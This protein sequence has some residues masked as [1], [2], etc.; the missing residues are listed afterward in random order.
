M[1]RPLFIESDG[2]MKQIRSPSHHET[3]QKRQ[4]PEQG[5]EQAIESKMTA[6]EGEV[7]D[8]T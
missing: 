6:F 3:Q 4:E 1:Q 7:E 8:A 5:L 2:K